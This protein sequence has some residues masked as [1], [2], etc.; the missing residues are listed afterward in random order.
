MSRRTGFTLL[1]VLLAIAL[2]TVLLALL[3]ITSYFR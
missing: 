1:E 2:S 3:A